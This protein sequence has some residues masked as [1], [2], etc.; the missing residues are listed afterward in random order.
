MPAVFKTASFC[1]QSSF[2]GSNPTTPANN[3]KI[4]NMNWSEYDKYQIDKM[5]ESL[6]ERGDHFVYFNGEYVKLSLLLK[7]IETLNNW[8]K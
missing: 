1:V 6:K 8:F 3:L 7:V 4:M 2:V 5:K